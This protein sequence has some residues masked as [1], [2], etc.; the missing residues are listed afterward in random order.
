MLDRSVIGAQSRPRS[1]A[2]EAG[3]LRFFARAVGE[4]NPIYFDD[5][6][7]RTAGHAA[8]PA[9]PTFLF[10]LASLAPDKD[11][12]ISRLGV[13]M[14]RVLH[15]EQSFTYGA[16]IHAGDVVTLTTR[17]ADIYEKRGGALDFIVQETLATN[18]DGHCVGSARTVIVVRNG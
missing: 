3:Q 13:D 18:Q 12:V 7:A 14:G 6:A 11:D 10:C 4:T 1:I 5:E 15:G 2:V 9:P 16:T 8:L 17:V